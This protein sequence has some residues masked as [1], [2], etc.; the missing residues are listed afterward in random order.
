MI[1]PQNGSLQ[2]GL[3]AISSAFHEMRLDATSYAFGEGL[4]QLVCRVVHVWIVH[5]DRHSSSYALDASLPVQVLLNVEI[6]LVIDNL[7]FKVGSPFRNCTCPMH[8]TTGGVVTKAIVASN[9]ALTH[10]AY[11]DL[12]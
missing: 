12:S 7:L 4:R 10:P 1:P 9:V 11:H 3:I 8:A 2:V 6:Q 5:V